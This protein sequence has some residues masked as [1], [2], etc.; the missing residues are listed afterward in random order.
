MSNDEEIPRPRLRMDEVL[1]GRRITGSM[2]HA[3]AVLG[4]MPQDLLRVVTTPEV[5]EATASREA[6]RRR[7]DQMRD[8]LPLRRVPVTEADHEAMKAAEEKRARQRARRAKSRGEQ[9]EE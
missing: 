4:V 3:L 8:S 6:S 2:I 7:A 5:E 1:P 9:P